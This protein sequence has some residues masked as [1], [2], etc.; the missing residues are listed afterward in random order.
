[1]QAV[2]A[3]DYQ[4][5]LDRKALEQ[6]EAIPGFSVALKGFLKIFSETIFHG[7]NMS[8]KIRLSAEQL[9]DIY[10][11]LPPIC[12]VLAID[13]PELYLEMNPMPN[14]YTFGDSTIFI[15]LTSGL[16]EHMEE[17]EL[18]AVI[19]HECGHI[20]CRHVLY[21]T[22]ATMILNGGTDL[23]G[24]GLLS[25]PLQLGLLHWQRCSEFSCDRAAAVYLEGA[26]SVV[27]TM[28]RLA[29]GTKE[30][31][32]NINRDLYLKQADAYEQLLDSS[33]W[34]KA[35]QYWVLMNQT[36]PFLSVRASEVKKWC[37]TDT[38]K[39]IINHKNDQTISCPKCG[40]ALSEGWKFCRGCGLKL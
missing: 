22:M 12:E 9:P 8:G 13:E 11:L 26:D 37:A 33:T 17:D 39:T 31:T 27:E 6:L 2:N 4:H 25:M 16:I 20:A 21:N 3:R 28:I 30:V 34:N 23:L 29:G 10:N 5:D 18:K 32:A 15:T 19:A 24:L 35:L 1:M 36:H 38:F 40:R 14:A 7:L